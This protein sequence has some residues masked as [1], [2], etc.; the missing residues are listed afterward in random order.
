MPD[1]LS[2]A[3]YLVNLLSILTLITLFLRAID[4]YRSVL[5]RAIIAAT[6]FV[7]ILITWILALTFFAMI[8]DMIF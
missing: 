7:P 4:P 5:G 1:W 3:L 6:L 8:V 2:A